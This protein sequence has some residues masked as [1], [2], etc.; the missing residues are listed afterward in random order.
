MV[1]LNIVLDIIVVVAIVGVVSI[2]IR[3]DHRH[4]RRLNMAARRFR[5]RPK[6]LAD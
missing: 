1:A 6:P 4:R 5:R 3:F 2:G